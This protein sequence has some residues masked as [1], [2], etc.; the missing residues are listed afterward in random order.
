M[1]ISLQISH[2]ED[3]QVDTRGGENMF[4]SRYDERGVFGGLL[5][6]VWDIRQ[7]KTDLQKAIRAY[8]EAEDEVLRLPVT[9]SI[10]MFL[11][12]L[13]TKDWTFVCLSS[14]FIGS[15]CQNNMSK[16]SKSVRE[17]IVNSIM[18]SY[19]PD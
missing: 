19:E 2:F 11:S 16:I 4:A 3:G 1:G 17:K 8:K 12:A 5:S 9:D 18:R 14:L 6:V 7:N 13:E 15:I 10:P